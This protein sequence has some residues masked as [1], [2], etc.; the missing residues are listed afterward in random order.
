MLKLARTEVKMNIVIVIDYYGK[1][2]NGTTMTARHLVKGLEALGHNVKVLCGVGN[3]DENVYA[4]GEDKSFLPLYYV[5]KSQG[6]IMGKVDWNIIKPVLDQADV[7]HFLAGFHFER[8]I[9]IYCD[10]HGIKTTAAFHVQPENITSTVYLGK[11]K[12]LNSFIYALYRRFFYRKFTEIHCPSNMIAGQLKS[13]GYKANLHVISN[14]ISP[15]F[16]PIEA[17]RPKELEGKYLITMVGRISREKR[18]DLL[19]RAIA[20]SKYKDKIYLMLP[21]SGPWKGTIENMCKKYLKDQS[22]IGW[23]QQDELLKFLNYA[24]LYVH[25]SDIEI[26]AISCM[27]AF[28]CGMVP[29]IS[30]SGLSATSQ[31]ALEE[32][33]V[34]EAGNY[35]DLCAK[36]EYWIE[37]EEEKKALSKKYVEYAKQFAVDKCVAQLEQMLVEEYNK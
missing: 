35:K 30:N 2:T 11:F 12:A 36:I 15:K 21:G 33:N 26:E 34:F 3:G 29:V 18:Q 28:A 14:G 13:H 17:N 16:H 23:V 7:V 32:H 27:E 19:I 9:K 6:F 22:Y 10:K 1:S 20:H 4:T 24:D 31:F 5:C 37:H 25:A 8:R